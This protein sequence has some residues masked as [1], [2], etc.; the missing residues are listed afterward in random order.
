MPTLARYF[1]ATGNGGGWL[2]FKEG[3]QRPVRKLAQK[4]QA[5]ETARIMAREDAP[6]QVLVEKSDGS[7][8]EQ[9]AFNKSQVH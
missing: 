4:L 2:V 7:F 9:Y 8:F 5:V 1:V 3:V 6:S